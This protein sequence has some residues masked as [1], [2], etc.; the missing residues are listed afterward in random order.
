ML[1]AFGIR[2][3][4][5]IRVVTAAAPTPLPES[6]PAS[7]NALKPRRAQKSRRAVIDL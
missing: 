1:A 5:R 2:L 7:P 4:T 6:H 3:T